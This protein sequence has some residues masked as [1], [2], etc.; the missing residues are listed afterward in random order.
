MTHNDALAV[1]LNPSDPVEAIVRAAESALNV[2][3]RYQFFVW[4]QSYLGRLIPHQLAVCGSY[5]RASR[6]L[7]FD[8]FNS[9]GLEPVLM[10]ALGDARS[11][12]MR[13]L[14]G[15]WLE[16][17]CRPTI[18]ATAELSFASLGTVRDALLAAQFEK[19]LVHGM[20]RPQR[21]QE[22]ESF[23]AF[24]AQDG[25]ALA[26]HAA[27]LEL[28][29]PHVHGAWQRVQAVERDVGTGGAAV[30]PSIKV[31]GVTQR[32]REI[33]TWLREGKS[34][35]QIA[36]QLGISALTVKNHVQKILRK[37]GAANRAQAVAQA[38]SL[39]LLESMPGAQAAARRR[40]VPLT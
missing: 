39:Q 3:R 30:P 13:H 29:L 9:F 20:S 31:G 18:V 24:A 17:R 21:P 40:D 15:C 33:L 16:A 36:E 22:I 4:T 32:E 37:L 34:N 7:L 10:D 5:D 23:F 28:L 38:M 25:A 12:L 11:L 8:V 19:I 6:E 35:Q 2:R 27:R 14:Q 26:A 1:T